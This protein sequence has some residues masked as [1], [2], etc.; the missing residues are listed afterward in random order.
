MRQFKKKNLPKFEKNFKWP[1]F[2]AT[3]KIKNYF[4]EKG[5]KSAVVFVKVY[6]CLNKKTTSIIK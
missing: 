1:T 5:S 3:V 2:R 6:E 4:K